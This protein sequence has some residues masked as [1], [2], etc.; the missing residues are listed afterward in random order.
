MRKH[1][2][3]GAGDCSP[4]PPFLARFAGFIKAKREVASRAV[5]GP[6]R[7]DSAGDVAAFVSASRPRQFAPPVALAS[8]LADATPQM[9][10]WPVA[11]PL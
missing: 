1:A 10:P 7:C 6:G 11:D 8:I 4:V 2:R 3:H 9:V 5:G